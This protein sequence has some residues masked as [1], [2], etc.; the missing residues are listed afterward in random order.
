[1]V[2]KNSGGADE[3]TKDVYE[4]QYSGA[5][6]FDST[7]PGFETIMK[8]LNEN[9]NAYQNQN[10]GVDVVSPKPQRKRGTKQKAQKDEADNVSVAKPKSSVQRN[11]SRELTPEDR[12]LLAQ[13]LDDGVVP[14][15]LEDDSNV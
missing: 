12:S 1:M 10:G 8:V 4:L 11:V 14:D 6:R 15:G 3:P 13:I 9:L 2:K 5:I 7:L